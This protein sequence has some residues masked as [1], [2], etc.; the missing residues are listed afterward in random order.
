MMLDAGSNHT[1]PFSGVE[2]TCSFI[3]IPSSLTTHPDGAVGTT[4]ST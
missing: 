2:T 1:P 3:Y 4:Q